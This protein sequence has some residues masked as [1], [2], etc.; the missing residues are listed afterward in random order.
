MGCLHHRI[1][2]AWGCALFV[3]LTFLQG[4]E[5]ATVSVIYHRTAEQSAPLSHPGAQAALQELE[6]QLL[7]NQFEVVQAPPEVYARMGDRAGVML[8]FDRD[9]GFSILLDGAFETRPYV[10]TDMQF[11]TAALKAR[12]M[13]GT[14][15]VAHVSKLSQVPYRVGP[16]ESRAY[17]VAAGKAAT[18]LSKDIAERIQRFEQS[19]ATSATPAPP[20]LGSASVQ[21]LPTS[22]PVGELGR[23][24]NRFAVLIGVSSFKLVRKQNPQFDVG[25]LPAVRNDVAQME[26]AL[27]AV[28]FAPANIV[29]LLD[30]Q[31]T[32]R[33]VQETLQKLQ[34]QAKPDDLV[35]VYLASHGA[36]RNGAYTDFG[37]PLLYDTKVTD[38][39]PLDFDRFKTLL[40][41]LP[42]KQVIW[43]NDTCHSGGA[44][45]NEPAVVV[46]SRSIRGLGR[47]GFDQAMAVQGL[48]KHF[49]VFASSRQDQVSFEVNNQG[50]FSG[51]FSKAILATQGQTGLLDL[52][53]KHLESQ[54]PEAA[55]KLPCAADGLPCPRVQQPG[56]AYTGS[57]NLLSFSGK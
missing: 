52:F 48:D 23:V 38:P 32:T 19:Q 36:P 10:G 14:Q 28:G 47:P 20:H 27:V 51:I 39:N 7:E 13:Y 22:A 9:S 43:A 53:H 46:S 3:G 41:N 33:S 16:G 6:N 56:F 5:A 37:I 34:S 42:A 12:V 11:A 49:A 21:V 54:V 17:A 30:D 15:V 26:K 50:I 24:N 57:G 1:A 44:L 29:T 25:D 8:T 18:L 45:I 2:T 35:F 55:R 40:K 31:A 4:V